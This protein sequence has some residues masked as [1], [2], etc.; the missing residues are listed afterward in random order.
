MR[1][2]L[3]IAAA[4]LIVGC[5]KDPTS[6]SSSGNV[7]VQLMSDSKTPYADVRLYHSLAIGEN[8]VGSAV[9]VVQGQT[10]TFQ[11]VPTGTITAAYDVYDVANG[12]PSEGWACQF[13]LASGEVKTMLFTSS[14]ML[15]NC[16][17]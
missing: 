13:N 6:P 16:P 15:A 5:K 8:P 14:S 3:L 10:Y 1:W 9:H 7:A 17:Q 12:R 4:L 11:N 2:L